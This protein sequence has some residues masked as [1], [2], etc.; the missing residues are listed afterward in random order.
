MSELGQKARLAAE[1]I[2]DE[3][4]VCENQQ[5]RP[6]IVAEM[7]A[8]ITDTFATAIGD[9][10]GMRLACIEA[11]R[12]YGYIPNGNLEDRHAHAIIAALRSVSVVPDGRVAASDI[13]DE[14]IRIVR[15]TGYAAPFHG[16]ASMT[17]LIVKALEAARVK[18]VAGQKCV[19]CGHDEGVY[20]NGVCKYVAAPGELP[21]IC[22]CVFTEGE[23]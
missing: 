5:H 9:A 7:V 3:F 16:N 12:K 18:S 6:A 11:V 20:P 13:W 2:V 1:K 19:K 17:I 10:E 21:C 23:E 8:I 15:E 14:A 4:A 22:E